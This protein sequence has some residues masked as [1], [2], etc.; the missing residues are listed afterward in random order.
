M[1]IVDFPGVTRLVIPA[2]RVLEWASKKDLK[3]VVVMGYTEDGDEYFA[4]SIADGGEVVWLIER[5]KLKLLT[6]EPD[7]L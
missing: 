7:D 3:S 2:E 4:S 6:V 5:A 1:S